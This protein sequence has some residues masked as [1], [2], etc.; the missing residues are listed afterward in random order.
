SQLAATSRA[1]SSASTLRIYP[2]ASQLCASSSVPCRVLK[3]SRSGSKDFGSIASRR[4]VM[5][6]RFHR[7]SP[8]FVISLV[9]LFVALG[10]TTYAA[11]GGYFILGKGNAATSQTG[12][13]AN[14]AGKAL[15][16]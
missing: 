11:T 12:L 9:A 2:R 16:I 13:T 5:L 8:A 3:G 14:N 4:G 1:R 7:P 15:N 10:G 6:K